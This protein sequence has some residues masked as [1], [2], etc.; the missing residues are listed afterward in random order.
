MVRK[1]DTRSVKS[2][3]PESIQLLIYCRNFDVHYT[4]LLRRYERFKEINVPGNFDIDAI[5]YLDMIVVQLRALCIESNIHKN[6]Y[7]AQILLRK[8]GYPDLAERIDHMLG[9]SFF[10]EEDST[11]V[12]IRDALKLL[13]DKFICH[14][15]NYDAP[16]QDNQNRAIMIEQ[17]LKNPYMS[18]NLDYIMNT[19]ISCIGKGIQDKTGERICPSNPSSTL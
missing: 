19:I 6:N 18:R 4:L 2:M 8:L 5:T 7:T 14:Y 16:E 17:Q 1:M 11:S 9:E 10:E 3:V 15:D 12:T 13:A